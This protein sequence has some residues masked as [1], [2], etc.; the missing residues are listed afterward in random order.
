MNKIILLVLT[1]FNITAFGQATVGHKA[2]L[3]ANIQK[4]KYRH[5]YYVQSFTNSGDKIVDNIEEKVKKRYNKKQTL[6]KY[7][8]LQPF[9]IPADNAEEAQVVISATYKINPSKTEATKKVYTYL[10]MP[11]SVYFEKYTSSAQVIIHYDYKDKS[12]SVIDTIKIEHT[13]KNLPW[14]PKST[15]EKLE[16]NTKED[17]LYAIKKPVKATN[18]KD[19]SII[20]PK[21]KIKDKSLKE[22]Y[23]QVQKLLKAEKY[24][25]AGK[26]CKK[27]YNNYPKSL[28]ASAAVGLCYELIGNYPKAEK[29]TKPLK[30]FHIISR[31][32]KNMKLLE[33]ANSIGF[34]PEFI[35]F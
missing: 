1:L 12:P 22:E 17:L 2:Y 10:E 29:Y 16:K 31:M 34:T 25:E 13:Y 6:N 9:Y 4:G 15:L 35:D 26:I 27:V 24:T 3:K 20:F 33:F 5:L 14:Y 32:R 11:Y 7:W 28:E 23:S 8:F 21:I 19:V 30:N 18:Y